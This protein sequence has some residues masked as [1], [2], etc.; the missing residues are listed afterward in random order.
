M[1]IY[2]FLIWLIFLMLFFSKINNKKIIMFLVLIG[3]FI[4]LA[5]QK[6]IG[7]DY[8]AYIEIF[9]FGDNR[10]EK[11]YLIFNKII[12]YISSND[13]AL[14]IGVAILQTLLLY[15]LLLKQNK[16]KMYNNFLLYFIILCMST[17][18]YTGMFNTLRSTIAVLSFNIALI[19]YLKKKYIRS[20]I[21]IFFGGSFHTSIY[22]VV[23]LILLLKK[24]LLK[25]YN[26]IF[27]LMLLICCFIVNKLDILRKILEIIYYSNIDFVYKHY[28][29]SYHLFAYRKGLGIA[30]LI[31][32]I[33]YILVFISHIKIKKEKI[34]FYNLGIL[35]IIL[36]VLFSGM[37]VLNRILE[38][39]NP[40]Y[41]FV[42]YCFINYYITKNR[43]FFIS[44]II[45]L[46]YLLQLIV[47]VQR[48]LNY[49]VT[50]D[51]IQLIKKELNL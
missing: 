33:I 5:T 16:I 45:L 9:R 25:E 21:F 19:Y 10:V 35:T 42:I 7:T 8:Y 46:F 43:T 47:G 17:N 36:T 23:I 2:L 51:K 41:A 28:F 6:N 32:F 40:F 26:R 22:I 34:L 3:M 20:F 31:N 29:I 15:N 50:N 27:L 13:R 4:S 30:T 49:N 39:F 1:N 14:F 38:Y 11:G 18:F 48:T 37:P 24:L 44:F 12:K